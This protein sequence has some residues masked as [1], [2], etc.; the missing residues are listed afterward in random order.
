MDRQT[1]GSL[2]QEIRRWGVGFLG[3]SI[4][5]LSAAV[6]VA[7]SKSVPS[8]M[9]V[10]DATSSAVL[11][12][13][14]ATALW[15]P[16]S[17]TKLMSL[18]VVF[19]ELSAGRLMLNETMTVSGY[20]AAMPPSRLGLSKGD[21]ISIELAILATITRSAND[22]V[23]ALAER[24][25]GDETS[26]AQKMSAEARKLGMTGSVF[27]NASG[28]PDP[29]QTTT[30]RDMAVLAMAL[31]RDFPQYYHFFS[32]RG[33][34]YRGEYLPTIN[35]ILG[36]Y[37][38][39]DGLK[40]GFTCGSGYNLVASAER[41]GRR[42]VGVV[43]GGLTS[44]QR[45]RQM[46]D[47]LDAGFAAGTEEDPLTLDQMAEN[48]PGAPPQQLSDEE[49]SPGWSLQPNGQVAGRL[50]GW[51][52]VFGGYPQQAPT[53][54]LLDR[55]V[56][57]LPLKLRAGRPAIIVRQYEGLRSFRAVVVGLTAAQAGDACRALWQ[58]GGYCLAL[59]PAVLNNPRAAWR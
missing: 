42:V 28:L 3:L 57:Q 36:L 23:V 14:Q 55:M 51:G 13:D 35:A 40:T 9:I 24:V 5:F 2:M 56:K 17:L 1:P 18:Y 58:G 50:P 26:F 37:P 21:K 49:C 15:R 25:G 11:K 38:G 46:T 19:E 48:A 4:A 8:A 29:E 16:A 33:V 32:A 45:Y 31:I 39:A 22:A 30:A 43:L 53:R 54:A 12:S 20:A 44:D 27:R 34:D 52:I 6:A 7:G 47:L 59:S 10:I 41:D